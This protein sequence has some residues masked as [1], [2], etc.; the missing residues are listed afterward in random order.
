MRRIAF[1][2]LL[3]LVMLCSFA[4][5]EEA[6]RYVFRADE[7]APFADD[8]ATFDLYV[9]PLLGADCMILTC[10][11]EAMLVDMGKAGDYE[12]IDAVL[13]AL[14]ITHIDIAFNTHP[15]DDHLGSMKKMLG[16]YTFGVFMTAFPDNYTGESVIQ[17]SSLKAIR[18]A[19]V[20]IERVADGDTFTI[21]EAK[22]EVIRQ[23]KYKNPNPL[24]AMLKVTFGG[25]SVLLTADVIG[26]AQKYLAETHDLKADIFKVP[27]HALNHVAVEFLQDIDPEYAFITHGYANTK[28]AQKQLNKYEIPHDFATWGMIHLSTNGEYWIVEQELTEDGK[29]YD[30]KYR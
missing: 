24:S 3:I 1:T 21:G 29:R 12:K 26:S 25:R 20:P 19:E 10:G 7:A 13:K 27:H 6:P 30:E 18:A 8:E 11:G 17:V 16:D 15:H 5:A 4:A 14:E 23:D 9:V 28:Q 22:C 2:M